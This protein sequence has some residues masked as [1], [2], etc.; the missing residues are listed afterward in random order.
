MS[1]ISL[2][3]K[4]KIPCQACYLFAGLFLSPLLNCQVVICDLRCVQW[5][6]HHCKLTRQNSWWARSALCATAV[7]AG[8]SAGRWAGGVLLASRQP[9]PPTSHL[10]LQYPPPPPSSTLPTARANASLRSQMNSGGDLREVWLSQGDERE[11]LIGESVC[12]YSPGRSASIQCQ[13][14]KSSC[15]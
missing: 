7:I 2:D 1:L 15:T 5:S 6:K 10:P 4:T 11:D 3:T 14:T 9:P 12:E 8:A 13:Q